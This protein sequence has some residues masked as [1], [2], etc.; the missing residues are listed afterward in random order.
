LQE[1]LGKYNLKIQNI[2]SANFLN[3]IR[4]SKEMGW[5]KLEAKKYPVAI[6]LLSDHLHRNPR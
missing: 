5:L 1:A 4:Y 6:G 2:E 3:Q